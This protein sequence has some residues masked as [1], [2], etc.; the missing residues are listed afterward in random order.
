MSYPLSNGGDVMS[1]S[2]WERGY[3]AGFMAG[4][5]AQR[6]NLE[7]D[8]PSLM[9]DFMR[10]KS[11]EDPLFPR[12]AKK[13]PRKQGPKQKLL[14]EMTQKKWKSYKR[15]TPKGKKTYVQIRAQVS[16]SQ[17]YKKKAKKLR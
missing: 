14:T 10:G 8:D 3:G 15:N 16:R 5:A 11:I 1:Q 6:A 2:D 12:A 17:A 4:L 7:R 13:K 9:M